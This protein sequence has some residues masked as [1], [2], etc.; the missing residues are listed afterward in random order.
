MAKQAEASAVP[1]LRFPEFRN[2]GEWIRRNLGDVVTFS[3]GG[4]PSKAEPDYW[5]GDIPWIS[6]SSMHEEN[7]AESDLKVT[8]LAIGQGARIAP[9]GSLLLLVRGS[10]LFNRVPMGIAL[11]D[12][13][14]N[15]DVKALKVV[16][17]VAAK[18]LLG[19]LIAISPRIP[20]NETGIG[21]GKIETHTLENLPVF[22]PPHAEQQKVADCLASLD[23][24]IAAQRRKVDVLKAHKRG[25]M[26]QLFPREGESRPRLRFPEFVDEPEWKANQVNKLIS[27]VTPP[28]KIPTS[29]YGA[30]GRL[31]IVDQSPDPICGWTDDLEAAI[32]APAPLIVFGDHTCVLKLVNHAFAQGADG[33]KIISNL[34]CIEVRFLYYALQ[35][36][37][38]SSAAYRRHFSLLQEK[39]VAFPEDVVEQ[40]FIADCLS[41]LDEQI[42]AE[43]N[44]LATLK[45]HRLGLMQQLFPFAEGVL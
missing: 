32:D 24:V 40:K 44:H 25:L 11:I 29:G 26:R 35:V 17:G 16:S 19:Q 8:P 13:A 42:T 23:E 41:S 6:A 1:K 39:W 31:P 15:Q 22:L 2:D 33:I 9:R 38:V 43:S 4:T 14:F 30:E 28:R 21:A 18:F 37:P 27:T 7:I 3:S 45:T 5:N 10:M 34:P 36:D 20:I 12:V